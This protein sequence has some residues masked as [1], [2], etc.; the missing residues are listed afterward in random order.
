MTEF[1][2]IFSKLPLESIKT[3]SLIAVFKTSMRDPII[4][5]IKSEKSL[6]F[7]ASFVNKYPTINESENTINITFENYYMELEKQTYEKGFRNFEKLVFNHKDGTLCLQ[8][9]SWGITHFYVCSPK[10][11]LF[12]ISSN[13][14]NIF[15]LYPQMRSKINYDAIIEYLFSHTILGIKT[16]FHE[17]FLCPPNSNIFIDFK[18]LKRNLKSSLINSEKRIHNLNYEK[19]S[20]F[21]KISSELSNRLKQSILFISRKFND[22]TFNI[23]LS[24][25][26]DS[27]VI[28][29][30]IPN[31][32]KEKAIALTFDTDSDG[33][34]IR[35]AEKIAENLS[36]KHIIKIYDYSDV[37]RLKEFHTWLSEGSSYIIVS[38]I[39]PL[40]Q[41]SKN[42][43]ILEGFLG[44]TQFGGEFFKA[45][46]FNIS[47]QDSDDLVQI[48]LNVNEKM[49][50][51]FTLD[52][53]LSIFDMNEQN[54]ISRIIKKGYKEL[55]NIFW[56]SDDLT[57]LLECALFFSR[58]R[59]VTIGGTRAM[60]YYANDVKLFYDSE[61]ISKVIMLPPED[62]FDRKLELNVLTKLNKN[63][64][65][66]GST[67]TSIYQK[68]PKLRKHVLSII[69]FMEKLT[70]RRINPYYS[71]NSVQS[72]LRDENHP[73]TQWIFNQILDPSNLLYEFVDYENIKKAFE[74]YLRFNYKFFKNLTQFLD[75]E[76]YFQIIYGHAYDMCILPRIDNIDIIS[77]ILDKKWR[78]R[79]P[80]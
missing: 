25:G 41:Q 12:V 6:C 62:R 78:I 56:N 72:W 60:E 55:F 44:D 35:S 36:I 53:F 47:S 50:Y 65:K 59:R 20:D 26:L 27:R 8:T 45:I 5:E 37:L 17:I 80:Y 79:N 23:M 7:T 49:G 57:M 16:Y 21:E 11:G 28:T 24:G 75:L 73:Y 2:F 4:K 67:S 33:R 46:D 38:S 52:Y 34:E 58:G 43:F 71:K 1:L 32:M 54:N 48:F 40:L 30:S 29:A 13:F 18:N 14:K 76:L 64:Q 39:H 63:I 69:Y 61:F 15:A 51:S 31:S 66:I 70:K 74:K 77:D 3:D 9:S 42:G 19:K 10:S 68:F 22:C